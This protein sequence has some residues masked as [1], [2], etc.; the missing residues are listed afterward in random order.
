[1]P[2]VLD[3]SV[4]PADAAEKYLFG[5]LCF[6]K[7]QYASAARLFAAAFAARPGMA[8]NLETGAR[9]SAANIAALAGCGQG[10]AAAKLDA[11]ERA[12][13]RTQALDWLRADLELWRKDIEKGKPAARAAAVRFLSK[14]QRE[15]DLA[16]VREAK[17][18]AKLPPDERDQWGKLWEEVAS[19]VRRARDRAGK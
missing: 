9:Y 15:P 4:E 2:G 6:Y 14:W 5:Q 3:G 11:K 13:W 19:L 12:R 7:G 17:A 10:K 1:L 16:G 18:L 8:N